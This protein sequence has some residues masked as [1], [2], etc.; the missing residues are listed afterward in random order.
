MKI[1][2]SVLLSLSLFMCTYVEKELSGL[3]TLGL[4]RSCGPSMRIE[5]NIRSFAEW[6][7]CLSPVGNSF[8]DFCFASLVDSLPKWGFTLERKNLFPTRRKFFPLTFKSKLTSTE[9]TMGRWEG[10]LRGGV[11][12]N[13]KMKE[14]LPR[15]VNSH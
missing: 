8:S 4:Q 3:S 13:Y 15:R 1:A 11:T 6:V 10:W 7:P 12:R 2:D 14:L 5:A 9:K